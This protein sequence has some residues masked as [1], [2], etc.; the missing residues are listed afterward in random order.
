MPYQ[1]PWLCVNNDCNH[2][3][4]FVSGGEFTPADDVMPSDISTRGSNLILK[5]PECGTIKTWY[6]SDPLV[7]TMNQ[8]IEV[9][10]DSVAKR[11]IHTLHIQTK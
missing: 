2:A 5:C 9:M 10:A 3:L 4:G 11:A 1:T 8:L 6:T 7:R